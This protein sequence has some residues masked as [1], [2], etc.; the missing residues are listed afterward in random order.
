VRSHL[1]VAFFF[2]SHATIGKSPAY[3]QRGLGYDGIE[4]GQIYALVIAVTI[5]MGIGLAWCSQ[6][7]LR[8]GMS[9]KTARGRYLSC[10]LMLA[11]IL[12]ASVYLGA[13]PDRIKIGILAFA[14]GLTPIIYS[15]GPAL[16]AEV[17]PPPQRGRCWR[18]T[19]RSHR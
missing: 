4:S 18:A 2:D 14:I 15:L 11:G 6:V 17:V 13:A 9:S 10:F 12:L 3:F 7:L 5:P 16:L 19:T 8:N 1:P